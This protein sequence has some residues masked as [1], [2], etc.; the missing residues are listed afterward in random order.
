MA[1]KAYVN[2]RILSWARESARFTVEDAAKKVPVSPDRLTEWEQGKERPTIRQAEILAKAYRRPFALFFLPDIPRDFQ[3]LTDFRRPDARPLGTASTFIIRELQQNQ[4]WTREFF[5]DNGESEL[6][7]VGRFTINDSPDHVAQDVLRELEINPGRYTQNAPIREWISKA[8][9]KGIFV[10]RTSFIHSRLLLNSEEL[11]GFVIA[12][13]YAPFVFI[14]SE[15]WDAPQL[16][17]FVHE[18]AHIWISASGIS[19]NIELAVKPIE[20]LHP[21][22]LFCNKVAAAALLPENIMRRIPVST[23]NN[24]EDVYA[25]SKRLGVSTFA[26]LY[27]AYN[28]AMISLARYKGLRDEADEAFRHYVEQENAKRALQKATKKGGPDHYLLLVQKNGSLF[29]RLVLDAFRGGTIASTEASN[30]LHTQ[31]NNFTKLE[32]YLH[33]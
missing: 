2:P 3:P 11:Q 23:F 6:S 4:A 22:E 5:R 24:Y 8:E 1:D 33:S 15:D 26:L 28:L 29:T 17:T 18:L 19:G 20:Q 30:L 9:A 27:R 10:S 21:V 14:N 13:K 16:F 25:T 31:T 12:D 32:A 7:F